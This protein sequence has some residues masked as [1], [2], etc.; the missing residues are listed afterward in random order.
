MDKEYSMT[1]TPNL[2]QWQIYKYVKEKIP[3]IR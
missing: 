3:E 1:S 2:L